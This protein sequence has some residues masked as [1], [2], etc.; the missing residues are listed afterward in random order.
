MKHWCVL[1]E[2]AKDKMPRRR[3][4][5]TE[6]T[7][8]DVAREAGISSTLF[9]DQI[10]RAPGHVTMGCLTQW[11]M[12]LAREGVEQVVGGGVAEVAEK[13]GYQSL[14]A[15]SPCLQKTFRM[16]P[17]GVGGRDCAR[18]RL[19]HNLAGAR[20]P[21]SVPQPSLDKLKQI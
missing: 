2:R 1:D 13:V 6:W 17:G 19:S 11:R 3:D 12:E 8:D 18:C 14:P 20:D 21:S 5:A 7:V 16:G 15:F 4:P 10:E 9:S